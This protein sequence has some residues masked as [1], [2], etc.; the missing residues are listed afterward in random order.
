MSVRKFLIFALTL[1]PLAQAGAIPLGSR[2]SLQIKVALSGSASTNGELRPLWSYSQ[3]W[4]RFTQFDR[5]E[6]NAYARAAW[7]YTNA[8]GWFSLTAGAALQACTATGLTMVHE[9]FVRGHLWVFDCSLGREAYTPIDQRSGLGMGTYI[10][11]DNARPVWKAA[12][13]IFE[14]TSLPFLKDWV[15]IRGGLS[16][17]RM[18]DEDDPSFTTGILLHEKFAYLRIGRLPVKPYVGLL[19]SAMMGGTYPDGRTMPVDFWATFFAKGSDKLLEA[20]YAGEYYN[21]AGGHQGMWDLGIDFDFPAFSGS[22]YYNRPFVDINALRFFQF[23]RCRDIK[24][25]AYVRL[26]KF[27]LVREAC[28]EWQSTLWQ[29]GN[30]PRD[31][32]FK[33]T[34]PERNGEII[35]LCA[36]EVTPEL[37]RKYVSA[38]QISDFESR[39]GALTQ[40]NCLDLIGELLFSDRGLD[41]D[42]NPWTWG[43][44][45]RYLENDWYP[46]GWTVGGLSTGSPLFLTDRVYSIIAPGY[47]FESRFPNVRFQA[48]SLG[49]SGGLTKAL[50]YKFK[51]VW[52]RNYGNFHDEY[53]DMDYQYGYYFNEKRYENYYFDTPKTEF[54]SGLWLD[55]HYK[56]YTFSAALGAD[57]GQMYSS[58]S[59][60]IG[61]SLNL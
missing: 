51:I 19:H 50:D 60:R 31:P 52:T 3:Q 47:S 28:L 21:V 42:G 41:P 37:L 10:L 22:L 8:P 53:L 30:G 20:G 12:A 32:V 35:G 59:A 14:Y 2:D 26:K 36:N 11:S 39:C 44:R 61:I 33:S 9:A 40:E 6:A 54:Y 23:A 56:K 43:N 18:P 7:T 1:L 57:F 45:S 58:F 34:G 16:V 49:L 5:F 25:G 48:L 4:G 38:E 29:G 55:Y 17:G 24:L 27:R 15:Q 46:Q 13:G